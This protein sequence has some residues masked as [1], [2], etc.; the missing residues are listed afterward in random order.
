MIIKTKSILLIRPRDNMPVFWFPLALA[1]LK[2][3][4]QKHHKVNILD[5]ALLDISATSPEFKEIITV[6]PTS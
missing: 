3:N 4:I 6:S 2:S 1:Y 5:C